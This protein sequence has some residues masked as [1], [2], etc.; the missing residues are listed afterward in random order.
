VPRIDREDR[1]TGAASLDPDDINTTL[2]GLAW[3]LNQYLGSD[4]HQL[5]LELSGFSPSS[6]GL[7]AYDMLEFA[8]RSAWN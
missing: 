5:H 2:D 6:D 8:I 1:G 7:T 4:L 3:A